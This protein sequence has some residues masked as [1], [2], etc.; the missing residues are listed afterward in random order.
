[1]VSADPDNEPPTV[2]SALLCPPWKATMQAEYDAL[3][4]QHTWSLVPPSASHRLVGNKWVFKI[5]RHPDG[6][7]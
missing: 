3:M 6:T 7:I 2:T 4:K 1:M 5:K